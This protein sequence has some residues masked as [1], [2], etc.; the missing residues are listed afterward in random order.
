MKREFGEDWV[1]RVVDGEC[2]EEEK[3]ALEAEAARNPEIRSEIRAAL[4]IREW[5]RRSAGA[6][7]PPE[8]SERLRRAIERSDFWEKRDVAKKAPLAAS[9]RTRFVGRRV[10]WA[11][12]GEAVAF[13][14]VA[15]ATAGVGT[16]RQ[17]ARRVDEAT[18]E[19]TKIAEFTNPENVGDTTKNA[20][21]VP[22][23]RRPE[24]DGE[25][26]ESPVAAPSDF[27]TRR[28]VDSENPRRFL[29]NFL[30]ICRENGVSYE[31]INGDFE[32]TL[33]ETSP[34]ARRE[35]RAW[36]DSNAPEIAEDRGEAK[37]IERWDEN[38]SEVRDARI[39]FWVVETR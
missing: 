6:T 39:S 19:I 28:A 7:V 37:L 10:V 2:S 11:A 14:A 26:P 29:M 30:K 35:I 33:L 24:N 22:L 8:F 15:L 21:P 20:Q 12:T 36:L 23:L 25:A 32:L 31:K 3:R 1:D 34:E 27:Y 4:R 9:R 38:D 18:A 17:T 16:G 13:A 5:A